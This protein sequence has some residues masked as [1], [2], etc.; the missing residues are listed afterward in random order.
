MIRGGG[1]RRIKREATISGNLTMLSI[2]KEL[3]LA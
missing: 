3:E 2:G 1:R